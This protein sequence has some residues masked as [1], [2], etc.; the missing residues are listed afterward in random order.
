MDWKNIKPVNLKGNQS[1][2]F[3]GWTDA[4]AP[5]LWP[6]DE[7]NTLT[8]KGPDAGKDWKQGEKGTTED[9]TVG[10]HHQLNGHEYEQALGVGDGLGSLAGCNP[11]GCEESDMAEQLSW[12]KQREENS[13]M[14]M[15]WNLGFLMV[16]LINNKHISLF[17]HVL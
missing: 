9:K 3:T 10:W 14:L 16:G 4:E 5:I 1:W 6:D 11:W 12:N 7:K 13:L 17:L 8:G 2:I 15:Y